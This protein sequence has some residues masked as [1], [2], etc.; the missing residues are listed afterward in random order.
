MSSTKDSKRIAK[1]GND[2]YYAWS[3]RMEMRLRKM[4]VW[5]LVDGTESRP[6][7]S[8][9][10]KV[11]KAWSTRMDLALS[12]IVC[13]VEDGQL[14]HTRISRDPAVVWARLESIHLS[15]GLGSAIS[16]WQKLFLISVVKAQ[17]L[18]KSPG[19]GLA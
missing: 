19:L 3:Y 14:V 15:Q 9:R 1:L 13:E 4:Q 11:V 7:G 6:D 2:N 18:Q 10:S 5:S 17:A 8:D 12:E 16:T